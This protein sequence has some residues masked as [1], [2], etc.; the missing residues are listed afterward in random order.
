[1]SSSEEEHIKITHSVFIDSGIHFM[2]FN[3]LHPLY[4]KWWVTPVKSKYHIVES[5]LLYEII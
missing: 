4:Y 5:I 3:H 2:C 1:M